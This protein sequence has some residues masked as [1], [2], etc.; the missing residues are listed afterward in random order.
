[1]SHAGRL[2]LTVALLIGATLVLA[3]LAWGLAQSL[4]SGPP[5][6]AAYAA[7]L[8]A[9]PLLRYALNSA[10]VATL[11]AA[12]QT[13]TGALAA[14]AF[15]RLHFPGRDALFL[16]FLG[17]LLLPPQVTLLPTFLLLQALGLIDTH[18]ALVAPSLVH[19]FTIF[20]IRQSLLGLPAELEDAARVEGCSRL[21]I[22]WRIALP[23]ASPVL[24]ATA[25]FSF[26]WSWNSFT[27]PLIALQTPCLYTLPV[28][29][30][31]LSGEL[32]T[33]LP[34]LLAGAT[35]ATLPVALLFLIAQRPFARAM[36]IGGLPAT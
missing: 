10:L 13:A 16:L 23:C 4:S 6:W 7:A 18:A 21:G 5:P 14:Y 34:T 28:G 22:L 30:A 12:G 24:I 32:G 1:M 19:P 35:V 27:W 11:T 8:R 25:L 20:L 3:P 9:A 2:G 31:M 36:E 15:S 17:A 26:L 29:L 33:D